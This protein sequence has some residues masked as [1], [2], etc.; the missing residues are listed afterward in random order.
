MRK[1]R[2]A[3]AALARPTSRRGLAAF[4][5]NVLVTIS[6]GR[7]AMGAGRKPAVEYVFFAALLGVKQWQC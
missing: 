3:S 4:G 1:S 2:V 6:S 5:G 7:Q